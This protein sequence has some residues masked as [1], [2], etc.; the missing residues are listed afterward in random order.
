MNSFFFNGR[1]INVHHSDCPSKDVYTEASDAPV[2]DGDNESNGEE[3]VHDQ[4]EVCLH[5][6]PKML[7]EDLTLSKQAI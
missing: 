3:P 2:S 7:G 4:S 1:Y 6:V 5:R